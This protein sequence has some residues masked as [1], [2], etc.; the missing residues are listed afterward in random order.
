MDWSLII[1]L[2]VVAL[3]A[4]R[5]Y[6]RGL[7]KSFSRILSLVAGYI[8]TIVYTEQVSK[9]VE[10]IFQLQGL[11]A[12][13]IAALF[14]FIAAGIAVSFLFLMVGKLLPENGAR[15]VA[16]SFGG[17]ALGLV[18]GVI[19]AF[20]IVWTFALV[21]DIRP[22]ET[23]QTIAEKSL[24]ERL[25]NRVASKAV[26]T[27]LSLA[28]AK[29][30]VVQLSVALVEAPAEIVQQAQRLVK[31]DDLNALLA[32]PKNQA[33]L[34]LGDVQAVQKL[35]AFQKLVNNPDMLALAK[36]AG[37]VSESASNTEAME[38]A[39]AG[40]LVDIWGRMQRVGNNKRVQEIVNDPEFQKKIQSSNPVDLLTNTALLELADIIFSDVTVPENTADKESSG[41]QPD[42][43]VPVTPKK[44]ITI[45]SWVDE[46]GRIH[47]SDVEQK[48]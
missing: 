33:V 29:P 11:I 38:A 6:R 35:P 3:F 27:A 37:M 26:R 18:V 17:T 25:T 32:D 15:S 36:S 24:I 44:E 7:V 21:R 16:S 48:P 46:N 34:N 45:Y 1:F 5:G 12:F 31:S 23:V 43:F 28:S 13:V 42:S 4:Y 10:S 19:V 2:V 41:A 39:L 14:L 22:S 47:Y 20:A 30:E 9:I 8:A 40:Q